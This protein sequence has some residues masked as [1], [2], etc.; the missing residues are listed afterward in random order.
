MST[1]A[2]PFSACLVLLFQESMYGGN[3]S[4]LNFL[5][6]MFLFIRSVS[7]AMKD[8]H[9]FFHAVRMASSKMHKGI[10]RMILCTETKKIDQTWAAARTLL[11][12]VT[13]SC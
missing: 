8:F 10:D 13:V 2:K 5:E 4:Y 9:H 11:R 6:K 3:C 7:M 12:A 1:D